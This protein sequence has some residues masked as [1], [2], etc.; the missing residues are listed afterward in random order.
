[1]SL[2]NHGQ[3]PAKAAAVAGVSPVTARKWLVRSPAWM[4]VVERR[5]EQAAESG[6]RV[7]RA[8]RPFL[9]AEEVAPA[10][11]GQDYQAD[12]RLAASAADRQAYRPDGRRV[13]RHGL[14]RSPTTVASA[15]SATAAGC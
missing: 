7:G 4:Q 12:Y 9:K 2:P 10:H 1:M 6:R 8:S 13:P 5:L 15:G 3:T 11:P 14:T